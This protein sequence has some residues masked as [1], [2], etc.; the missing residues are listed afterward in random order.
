MEWR[1]AMKHAAKLLVLAMF[2]LVETGAFAWN[3]EVTHKDLS[4][5]AA[6]NSSLSKTN[7]DYLKYIGFSKGLD[8]DKIVWGVKK[9]SIREWFAEG[10]KLED[11]G[12]KWDALR[13]K[14]RFNNHFHNPLK[15]W[16]QA[17]LTDVQTGES[18]LVWAQDGGAQ[19]T[20][21]EGVWTWQMA[22]QHYYQALISNIDSVRQENFAKTFRGLGHQ[23]HLLQDVAVPEHVRNDA[24]PLD[25]LLGKSPKDG[26][27]YFESWVK[28]RFRNANELMALSP[29]P[30]F[31]YVPFTVSHEGLS[32]VTQLFDTDSYDG[33]NASAGVNQGL[34]EYTNANFFSGDTIFANERYSTDHRHYFPFPRKESTDMQ[35]F[36][37]ETKPLLTQL[38][39]DGIEDKAIW[40]KKTGDGETIDHFVRAGRWSRKIYA[41]YGEGDRFYSSFYRDDKC[42]EDYAAK[43]IPRAVGYS[44]ALLNYFFRGTMEI[45]A[46]ERH[47]YAVTDGS[48]TPYVDTD[49]NTVHQRFTTIRAKILNTTPNEVMTAGI[50][51]AVA[52]YKIIPNYQPNLSAYPPNGTVMHDIAYSYSVSTPITLLPEQ[53]ASMNMYPTDFIFDFST[54]PIPAGITD[55][56][57]QVVYK[58]TLG[59]EQDI[60]VA[61]GMK[62]LKE[63]THHVF[64]NLSD[65][66]SLH[67]HLYTAAQIR[68][69]PDLLNLAGSAYIDPYHMNFS[70]AYLPESPPSTTPVVVASVTNLPPGRYIRLIALVGDELTAHYVQLVYTNP[71]DS[72]SGTFDFVFDGAVNKEADGVWQTPSA[73]DDLRGSIGHLDQGVLRCKPYSVDPATGWHVCAYPE[74]EAI[75]ANLTPHPMVITP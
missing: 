21:I 29:D 66:F 16:D 35:N 53:L 6:E 49:H 33:L 50:L 38:A 11:A 61:V 59:N 4:R 60:S 20:I 40:I 14:A 68:A 5:V 3:E 17:G 23:M 22:R 1:K 65:M 37:A 15:T 71:V 57:L 34:S 69:D 54:S 39:E 55:L 58:G 26:N 8:A 70:F 13:G 27:P 52:R 25:S 42:H 64:W 10:A 31:P 7:G 32:P 62:D 45:S 2:I 75:P 30:V 18:A 73:T 24:H 48:K 72:D 36:I 47:A 9:L 56:T 44:A 63:P 67:G 28:G 46:P 74:A 12:S 51:R 41:I 43:L 19:L